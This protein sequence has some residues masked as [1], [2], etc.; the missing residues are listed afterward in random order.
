MRVNVIRLRHGNKVYEWE[1]GKRG[2][3][4]QVYGEKY[5]LT[6]QTA[7]KKYQKKDK[8]Y[9]VEQVSIYDKKADEFAEIEKVTRKGK[10]LRIELQTLERDENED[11]ARQFD[12]GSG[13]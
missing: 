13:V 1:R 12:E 11:E 5:Y 2:G 9:E 3:T 7:V 4:P 10:R 6:E 8:T